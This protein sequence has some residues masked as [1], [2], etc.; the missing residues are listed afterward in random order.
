MN[1]AGDEKNDGDDGSDK[2][3]SL[4]EKYICI[5]ESKTEEEEKWAWDFNMSLNSFANMLLFI[6]VKCY[7]NESSKRHL[8]KSL[9][10]I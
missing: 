1:I 6:F 9:Y 5:I 2:T 4:K 7:T 8:Y 3:E 10:T